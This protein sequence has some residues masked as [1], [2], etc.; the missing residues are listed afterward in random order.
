ML[1]DPLTHSGQT[2][3]RTV[4]NVVRQTSAPVSSF[5]NVMLRPGYTRHR[6]SEG[7][8]NRAFFAQWL[9]YPA[10]MNLYRLRLCAVLVTVASL[11]R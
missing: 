8:A 3:G 4:H 11:Q 1:K 7:N 10:F 6:D 5:D 9:I 2:P